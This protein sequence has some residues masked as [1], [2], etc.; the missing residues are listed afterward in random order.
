MAAS[1]QVTI[2]TAQAERPRHA[3]RCR[4]KAALVAEYPP[5]ARREGL[6]LS[7]DF[8]QLIEFAHF[9]SP[10]IGRTRFRLS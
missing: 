7:N 9:A 10:E 3:V 2:N 6:P 5:A 4:L 1:T 8:R